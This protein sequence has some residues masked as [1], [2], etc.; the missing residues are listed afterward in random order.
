MALGENGNDLVMPVSPMYGGNGGFGNSFGNDWG[1]IIL[2]LLLAGNGGWGNGFGGFG[3]GAGELYPWMNQ[4]DITTSGFQNAQLSSTLSGLQSSVTSG[5]GDIQTALCGGFAGVNS[6]IANGFAQAEISE[7]ARQMANMNQM[8]NLS[9]QFANCCCENRLGLANLGSDI[10]REACADRQAVVDGVRDIIANQTAGIQTILT[11]MCNDKIDE[12]NSKIA[13]LERQLTMANLS[14]SQTAQTS[15]LLADNSAQTVALEQYL[16]P[17][18]V[19]AYIV[20]NP[21]CC[22]QNV[23]CGCGN[24]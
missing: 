14:A 21:N 22:N 6:N 23:G 20:N 5:F 2:L 16:N 1:W 10:A 7:N 12:K 4:A 17:V 19:P 18:P 9:S 13:D 15:R 24:F 11:Q 3:G 8:F